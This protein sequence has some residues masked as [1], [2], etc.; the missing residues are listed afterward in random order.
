MPVS[1]LMPTPLHRYRRPWYAQPRFYLPAIIG[2]IA[3][4]AVA[5]FFAA[6]ASGLRN[7]AATYD[8]T[9]LEQMESASMILDR[10]GKILDRFTS[11]IVRRFRT[12]NYHATWSTPLS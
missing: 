10:N 9:Q 6:L 2:I 8:L 4:I 5:T 1:F 3:L 11:R 7:Q 12:I